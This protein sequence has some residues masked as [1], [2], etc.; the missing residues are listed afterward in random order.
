MTTGLLAVAGILSITLWLC[1][2]PALDIQ[3][4]RPGA[5]RLNI[6]ADSQVEAPAFEGILEKSDGAPSDIKG[7]WPCFRGA[8]LDN[9]VKQDFEAAPFGGEGVFSELWT[10]DVGEGHA[11]A[12]VKDGR[13]YLMD[14][15]REKERDALRC[16]S[17]DD[18]KEIWRY[19][20]PVKIKRNHG[21]SRTVCAVTDKHVVGLGPKCHVVCLDAK[22]GELAWKID[23][24]REY[25]TTVPPWYAGQC[26]MIDNGRVIL[27]P[28]GDALVMAVDIASGEVIWRTPNHKEWGM[29]HSSI[30]PMEFSGKKFYVYCA[31]EGVV[32]VSAEDGELLW[33]TR[34]WKI[35]IANVPT[36][37]E[38]G[39]GRL[40]FCGGY[41]AGSV[42]I[43]LT[44][45]DGVITPETL[46]RLG[47]KKFG[48]AQQTP[49]FY[50][51]Y[52]YGVRPDEQLVCLDLDGQEV[53]TSTSANKF[54]LG[55]YILIG[56]TIYVMNDTGLLSRVEATHAEFRLLDSSLVL[57]DGAHSWGPMAYVSG[58]LIVRDMTRLSCIDLT[59]RGRK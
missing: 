46:F 59:V 28:G 30:I 13:V 23:L 12:A 24:V 42:M 10:I 40:F 43:K 33:E 3:E 50:N 26:P 35:R 25:N 5:D 11:G 34:D 49:I 41:E 45:K 7:D 47:P 58:R 44:D 8:D 15:D 51:G 56:S 6:S 53:W 55:P 27:A 20:Y 21:M 52:L 32:G 4:R 29:T 36:P 18:G 1:A 39:D 9:I 14:Y 17:L 54:G 16:L 57:K 22:T 38:V 48:S 19:S 2:D 37:V 31:S